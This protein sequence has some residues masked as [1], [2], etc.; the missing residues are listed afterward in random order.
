MRLLRS[1]LFAPGNHPRRVEKAFTLDADAVVLDLE[2]ACP[3]AE[4]VAA[5]TAVVGALQRPRRASGY[6]RINALSTEFGYGDLVAVVQHGV[7]GVMLTKVNSPDDVKLADWMISQQER[8]RGLPAGSVDLL[9]LIET[10]AGLA[11]AE[12]I[13]RASKRVRRLAFGAG[14]MTRDLGIEW[15]REETELLALRTTLVVASRAAGLEPPIDLAWIVTAD[16]EGFANSVRW[17]RVLGFQGKLCIHPEQIHAVNTAFSPTQA[18]IATARRVVEAFREAEARGSAAIVLDG[19]LVDYAIV[20]Q[21]GQ[22]LAHA[23][24]I[25]RGLSSAA[26]LTLSPR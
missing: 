3:V 13:G 21:A 2:D 25:A 7:D 17:G 14:D 5:R 15:T 24:R 8:E 12:A 10:G 22:V 1:L 16:A 23:E 20:V 9:P 26:D 18:Q 11:A 19:A 6:V 4:K